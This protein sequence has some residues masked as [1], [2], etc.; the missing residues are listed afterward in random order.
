MRNLQI[1]SRE[2]RLSISVYS[3]LFIYEYSK[4]A[5]KAYVISSETTDTRSANNGS[6]VTNIMVTST[7]ATSTECFFQ[8][9]R[10]TAKHAT[11]FMEERVKNKESIAVFY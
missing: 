1:I 4:L 3:N 2:L 8:A 10:D 9:S 7:T 11:N 6:V 5:P